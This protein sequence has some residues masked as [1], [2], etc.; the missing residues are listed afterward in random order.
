MLRLV[1]IESNSLHYIRGIFV[2]IACLIVCKQNCIIFTHTQKKKR[3]MEREREKNMSYRWVFFYYLLAV[4]S[5]CELAEFLKWEFYCLTFFVW[6]S[7]KCD[8]KRELLNNS[9]DASTRRLPPLWFRFLN[10]ILFAYFFF[11]MIVLIQNSSQN[12][13]PSSPPRTDSSL[14]FY[15]F[16]RQ[17]WLQHQHTNQSLDLKF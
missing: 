10:Y 13:S 1:S 15:F 4:L 5:Y 7:L 6:W 3:E 8:A 17:M 2:W 14:L 11:E 16:T 9:I 12:V